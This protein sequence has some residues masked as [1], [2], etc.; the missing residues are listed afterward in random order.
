MCLCSTYP[1]SVVMKFLTGHKT[2][3]DVVLVCSQKMTNMTPGVFA[4]QNGKI[5]G[6]TRD[7]GET[8]HYTIEIIHNF[9]GSHHLEN[10]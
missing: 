9:D 8:F 10:I 2:A 4:R 1:N 6:E 3:R 7:V 5:K